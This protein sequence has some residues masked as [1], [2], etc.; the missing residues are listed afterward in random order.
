[1]FKC[2]SKHFF[3]VVFRAMEPEIFICDNIDTTNIFIFD[4]T[5]ITS[6]LTIFRGHKIAVYRASPS[7]INVISTTK[8]FLIF[9]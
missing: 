6:F 1:M 5:I 9:L 4:V 3:G 7:I 2:Q 8:T